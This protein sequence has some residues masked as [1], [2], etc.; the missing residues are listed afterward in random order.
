MKKCPFCAEEIQDAA[1][2]CKHCGTELP[3]AS[4]APSPASQQAARP[5]APAKSKAKKKKWLLWVIIGFV[6][7]GLAGAMPELFVFVSLAVTGGAVAYM[8]TKLKKADARLI[9]LS[10]FGLFTMFVAGSA[11]SGKAAE[12]RAQE[13][14]RAEVARQ[15]EQRRQLREAANAKWGELFAAAKV[16]SDAQ[17]Y[18]TAVSKLLEADKLQHASGGRKEWF[19]RLRD[20]S[21]LGNVEVGLAVVTPRVLNGLTEDELGSVAKSRNLPERFAS[22]NDEVNEGLVTLLAEPAREKL[23]ALREAAREAKKRKAEQ[24]RLAAKQAEAAAKAQR[25]QA[26]AAAKAQREKN[27][28]SKYKV[29]DTF[30]LGDFSYAVQ[31]VKDRRCIGGQFTRTC[32]GEGGRFV[33]VYF[34]IRNDTKETK[35]VMTD[36]FKLMDADGNTYRT[37]SEGNTALMMSGASKDFLISELQPGLQKDTATVFQVSAQSWK[38]GARLIVPEKGWG[39]GEA[40]V[41]L[42]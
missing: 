28:A 17:D 26:K 15:E 25:E 7:L 23:K 32:A 4:S 34:A 9:G 31:R 6:W 39:T 21:V 35:T 14:R 19:P 41:R 33:I 36:D 12:E 38:K 18:E 1:I 16:A 11:W 40:T 42:R 13:E 8:A 29:G 30:T 37:S 20:A 2:K 27:V 22:T 3:P 10:V 24:E 5:P